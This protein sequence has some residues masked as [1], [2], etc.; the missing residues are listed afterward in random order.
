MFKHCT[1]GNSC[2]VSDVASGGVFIDESDG[3]D[4]VDS[5]LSNEHLF[6]FSLS[7][8]PQCPPQNRPSHGMTKLFSIN[9]RNIPKLQLT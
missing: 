1:P 6:F 3:R 4:G 2:F 7:S 8:K 9:H 5:R